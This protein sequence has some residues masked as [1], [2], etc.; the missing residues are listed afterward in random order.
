[1][2]C[3]ESLSAYLTVRHNTW[4]NVMNLQKE[5]TAL[6][7]Q[8]L[9]STNKYQKLTC[10]TCSSIIRG[11]NYIKMIYQCLPKII[12]GFSLAAIQQVWNT[13]LSKP[14]ELGTIRQCTEVKIFDGCLMV[15][16]PTRL[17]FL[18]TKSNCIIIGHLCF[19]L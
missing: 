16:F 15:V 2:S 6:F 7:A 10:W 3:C 18:W 12:D 5:E 17:N 8:V 1:M 9:K 11:R 19:L 14:Y 4:K 13:W